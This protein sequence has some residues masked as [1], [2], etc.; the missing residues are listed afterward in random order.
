MH[1]PRDTP[2]PTSCARAELSLLRDFELRIDDRVVDVPPTSQRLIGFL[3]LHGGHQV[4]RSFVSGSL[5]MDAPETRAF[6]SLRSA[7][8][9]CPELAGHP[10]VMTSNTHL[11]LHPDVEVDFTR[12][13]QRGRYMLSV[14]SLEAL[15]L[16]ISSELDNFAFDILV[17]WYDDWVVA[18]RERFRQLRLHVLE[19]IGELLLRAHQFCEAVQFGLVAVASDPLRESA[20]R[21]LV[22]AHLCEGNLAEA[23]RQYRSY[24][25]LLAR[26]LQV[27]PSAAME[28]LIRDAV[29]SASKPA[30]RRDTARTGRQMAS[31][32]TAQPAS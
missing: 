24:S 31:P 23:V 2:T 9:R 30:W 26:E 21:L 32:A 22:R 1:V 29:A 7:I 4:R 5:W 19:Q 27:R 6:A 16:D 28:D 15:T 3:A 12:A 20:H 17:N 11:W 13:A 25:E 10:L 14:P 8:W 18:E